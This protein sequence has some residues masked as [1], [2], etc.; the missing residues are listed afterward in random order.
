M[1]R[2]DLTPKTCTPCREGAEP[3]KGDALAAYTD[4]VPDWTVIEAH[5]LQKQFEFSDFQEA[6]AFV[7]RVG[8]VAEAEGHHP[9]IHF[10]YG[11]ATIEV[12]THTVDG[13]TE[14]DFVLA[15]KIDA[16]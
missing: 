14:N 8:E 11:Q 2:E 10:T 7:N 9:W 15:A 12:W 5:H 6:L 16:L 3:L 1:T 13:L 4:Q